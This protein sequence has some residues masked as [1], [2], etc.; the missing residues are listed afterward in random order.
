MRLALL[1]LVQ[2]YNEKLGLVVSTLALKR[3]LRAKTLP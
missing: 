3:S 1:R 2:R